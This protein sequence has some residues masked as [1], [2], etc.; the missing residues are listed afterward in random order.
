[1]TLSE[2]TFKL[3]MIFLPGIITLTIVEQLTVHRA[4][5]PYRYFIYS[6]LFGF[7]CY[8]LYYPISL[9]PFLGM[10]FSFF[11]TLSSNKPNLDFKEIA[12]ATL[13]AIPLGF[14][15]S[16]F[17]NK[18]V[19]NKIANLLN[20]TNKFGEPD[21][22]SYIMN[23]QEPEWVI[24]RDIENDL[25]YEGWV[26]AF[27]ES[28]ERDELFLRDVKVYTNK[29]AMELYET[30]GLYLPQSREKLTIEFPS[31]GFSEYKDRNT[32]NLEVKK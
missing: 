18:K 28:G 12:I 5:E 11:K 25:M 27:S 16:I 21:V 24:V 8:F 23:S 9:I 32:N 10:D 7:C 30:P 20:I 31:L 6:L 26:H 19:L 22:W 14:I 2:F 1:M 3:I 15:I 29:T 4:T 17:D 13:L